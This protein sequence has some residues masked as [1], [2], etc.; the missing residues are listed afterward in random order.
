MAAAGVDEA[1]V[2]PIEDAAPTEEA[3][4]DPVVTP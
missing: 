2:N 3:A 4:A 1:A